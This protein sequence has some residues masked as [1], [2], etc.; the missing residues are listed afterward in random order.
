M[1]LSRQTSESERQG[2]FTHDW[3]AIFLSPSLYKEQAETHT[4]AS[5][6]VQVVLFEP[7]IQH[8]DPHFTLDGMSHFTVSTNAGMTNFECLFAQIE[9]LVDFIGGYPSGDLVTQVETDFASADEN[10]Y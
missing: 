6:V 1:R 2:A 4:L 8:T 7:Y 3:L 5:S 10:P 9:E